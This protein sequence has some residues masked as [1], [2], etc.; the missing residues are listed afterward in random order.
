[1]AVFWNCDSFNIKTCRYLY[2]T[3]IVQ[4]LQNL[5]GPQCMSA[6]KWLKT[7]H[8]FIF[9]HG[10]PVCFVYSIWLAN[11]RFL[12]QL[13]FST[14][15]RATFAWVGWCTMLFGKLIVLKSIHNFY[16]SIKRSQCSLMLCNI[17]VVIHLSCV[18]WST[19]C[20]FIWLKVGV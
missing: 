18:F 13:C 8:S 3:R 4:T 14:F 5:Y 16:R 1:M 10:T 15:V 11:K 12:W 9:L 7:L 19:L 17:K 2:K 6:G 20:T